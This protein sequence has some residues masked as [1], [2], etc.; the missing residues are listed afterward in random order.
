MKIKALCIAMCFFGSLYLSA[1]SQKFPLVVHKK[2]GDMI[3]L[4]GLMKAYGYKV[5]LCSQYTLRAGKQ[6]NS[7]SLLTTKQE[8]VSI[9]IL[10]VSMFYIFKTKY[11]ET[12]NIFECGYPV[13]KGLDVHQRTVM[14]D[15]FDRLVEVVT[16]YLNG[17]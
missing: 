14:V 4:A 6:D 10:P 11:E 7:L 5:H 13:E 12:N 3:D 16:N 1:S 8:D 2:I 9:N 17:R 15:G